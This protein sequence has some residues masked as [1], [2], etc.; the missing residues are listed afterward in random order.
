MPRHQR[1]IEDLTLDLDE[2]LEYANDA[3]QREQFY[4]RIIDKLSGENY[5]WEQ[6]YPSKDEW[7]DD[8]QFN[9]N[10]LRDVLNEINTL[11]DEYTSD[12][13]EL[14]ILSED[15]AGP[16][17]N[18]FLYNYRMSQNGGKKKHTRK[19]K[20]SRKSNRKRKPAK[21][22]KKSRKGRRKTYKNKSHKK[23]GK[24]SRQ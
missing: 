11:A 10:G 15:D 12:V 8:I 18:K 23:S 4:M 3:I 19:N 6:E 14:A 7:E 2:L 5:P 22:H 21:S 13:D 16:Y 24:K 1:N 20:K 9:K 17:K